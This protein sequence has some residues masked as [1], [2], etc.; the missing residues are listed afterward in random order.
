M[1]FTKALKTLEYDKILGQLAAC[2]MTEGARLRALAAQ[3]TDSPQ[4][5]A[6]RLRQT[7]DA[8]KLS[9]T[10]GTPSFGNAKDI[11][12]SVERAEKGAML[13]PG[14]LLDIADLLASTAS[15]IH[16]AGNRDAEPG[17]L[18]ELFSLLAANTPLEREIRRC[19]LSADMISDDATPQLADI[20]RSIARTNARI[21]ETLQRYISSE[22]TNKYLQDNLVTIREG[23]YVI[24]VKVEHKNE[25]KG[26]VHDTSSSG[27]TLFVEP[28]AVVEANN[29]LR[30]LEVAEKKEIE[31][32]LY[33]LSASAADFGTALQHNYQLITELAFIFAR[34]EL[35]WRMRATEPI[36]SE[37]GPID[38]RAAR[39]PLLRA[40]ESGNTKKVVPIDVRLGGDFDT[41]VITGPNTGGKTVTLK[42]LGLFT[43]MAQTGLHIPADDSSKLRIVSSVYADIGDEQSIEQ[44]LST[45]SAHMTHIVDILKKAD[46]RS[47]V[48]FDE[49]GAGTDPTEGAALAVSIIEEVRGRGALCAATTHYSEMKVYALETEGVCNAACEFDVTTL[50]PTYRLIIGAPGK[51]NAFAI[52]SRLGLSDHIIERAGKLIDADS[53]R[54]ENVIEKLEENRIETEKKLTEAEE[55]RIAYEKLLK[56]T[57]EKLQ[58]QLDAAERERDKATEQA[59]RIVES[60]RATSDYVL[61]ELEK[62]KKAKESENFAKTLEETRAKVRQSMRET[63]DK[64]NPVIERSTENY[65]PSR[66][67]KKGDEVLIVS[68][69]KTGIIADGPDKQGNFTVKAGILTTKTSAK[70]L[71]L[72]ADITVKA[73]SSTKK[74]RPAAVKR[75]SSS[76]VQNFKVECDIR[77]MNGEDGWF[78]VDRYLDTAK[79]AGVHTVRIIHG[80]GTGA[81]RKRLWDF[82]KSDKRIASYR[83]GAY[84]E[85]DLGVTVIELK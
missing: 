62:A 23:R 84:G 1:D 37:D 83:Y 40:G 60:A 5:I 16:Y 66:P 54:F 21:R 68:L 29:A 73:A 75:E 50:A 51:S 52:S 48:L 4:E 43:L 46:D 12:D 44:S 31:K 33:Q 81:L 36:L 7:G 67:M 79:M 42:T 19:I 11:S 28:M 78:V 56:E 59:R 47:L 49:L 25:V 80:K 82:F 57:E 2:A 17:S 38:L 9:E 13:S 77:G 53:K 26:L 70:N 24:P 34:A 20:R 32:I 72:T 58:R 74:Q 45:F 30:E 64:I 22:S 69:N 6:K 15:L 39:H 71:M 55:Y 18:S 8:K 85:G 10:S 27:A 35:S 3:P 41:L 61:A 65:T 76:L 63:S 14:E